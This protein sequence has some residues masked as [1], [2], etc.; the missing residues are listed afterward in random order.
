M[1]RTSGQQERDDDVGHRAQA[2]RSSTR[3][4]IRFTPLTPQERGLLASATYEGSP[5]HKRDPGDFGLTPP[6]APRAEKTLCDE[7]GITSREAAVDLFRRAVRRGLVSEATTHGGYPKQI[8]I[9]DD[10]G[11]VFEAMHGGNWDGAY[12]G[13]PIRRSDPLHDLVTRAWSR[14]D[15]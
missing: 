7:A 13:Y 2:L 8:W 12:H 10:S 9:V 15:E 11:R 14:G 4:N 5:L 3:R 1:M 6:A